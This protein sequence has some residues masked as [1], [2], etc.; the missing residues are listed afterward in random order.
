MYS[1]DFYPF[2]HLNVG[3]FAKHSVKATTSNIHRHNRAKKIG[4]SKPSSGCHR[5]GFQGSSASLGWRKDAC[6]G[7]LVN[8]CQQNHDSQSDGEKHF[9]SLGSPPQVVQPP[10]VTQIAVHMRKLCQSLT[11]PGFVKRYKLAY[12]PGVHFPSRDPEAQL[13]LDSNL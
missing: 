3:R 10:L 7:P 12:S 2:L 8:C 13:Q 5:Q 1:F 6:S 9:A 4:I 11:R